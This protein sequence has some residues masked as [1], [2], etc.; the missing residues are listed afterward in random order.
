MNDNVQ[1]L[2]VNIPS[3]F[4]GLMRAFGEK[5][6]AT[7]QRVEPDIEEFT[8]IALG[9]KRTQQGK[10]IF[11][12]GPPGIGKSSFLYS[13]PIFQPGY[14][15]VEVK[16]PPTWE[17]GLSEIPAYIMRNIPVTD[18]ITI[19]TVDRRESP[20]FDEKQFRGLMVDLN[21]LL[22][23]RPDVLIVWPITNRN[24]AEQAISMIK[25]AG[26]D[27][28]F[29]NE[30]I[31]NLTGLAKEQYNHVLQ[32]ILDINGVALA[33][34]AVDWSEVE[35]M[36]GEG[37]TIGGF[38]DRVNK[39][40]SGR[41]EVKELGIKLPTIVF[42]ISSND[43]ATIQAICRGMRRADKYL[44][45]AA[46]LTMFTKNSNIAEWWQER[47]KNLR[48]AL[49]YIITMFKAQIVCLSPS[50]VVYSALLY[51]DEELQVL[52][53][54][55]QRNK[56]NGRSTMRSTE[57]VKFFY[58]KDDTQKTGAASST[59]VQIYDKIQAVSE[60]KHKAINESII[61]LALDTEGT[62]FENPIIE[63]P[64]N[65]IQPDVQVTKNSTPY[66]I[67]FH[68]KSGKHCTENKVAIYVLEKLK[69]YAIAYGLV[70][71]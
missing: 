71:R 6:P 55:P 66:T 19:I 42:A 26:G 52:A 27:S 12:Y 14:F 15:S 20:N 22:R 33:D 21:G 9:I 41:L 34:F 57:F 44:L 11:L 38:L 45:E 49:P 67:E 46:R 36:K 13:L 10:L 16:L 32:T 51:G 48:S 68:H 4:E 25:Q 17:L 7:L 30:P 8:K 65:G 2:E 54:G 29:D 37:S 53:A 64:L 31:V 59:T 70:T 5:A 61:T 60:S 1:D 39:L 24:F 56:G 63:E 3:R 23:E 35:E 69:E 18:K 43:E 40:I 50:S 62:L 58:G 47:A 28:A